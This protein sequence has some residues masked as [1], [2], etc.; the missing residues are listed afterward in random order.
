MDGMVVAESRQK[1][2]LLFLIFSHP[3]TIS[4]ASGSQCSLEGGKKKKKA[5]KKLKNVT[6]ERD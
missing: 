6:A 3:P 4:Q 1:P 2:G 5:D